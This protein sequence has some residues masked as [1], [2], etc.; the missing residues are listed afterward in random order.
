MEDLEKY[1]PGL[2]QTFYNWFTASSNRSRVEP[3]LTNLQFYKVARGDRVLEIVGGD[4]QDAKFMAKTIKDSHGD[5]QDLVR[6]KVDSNEINYNQTSTSKYSN[7]FVRSRDATS[8]FNIPAE[9]NALPAAEKPARYGQW[10]YL[11]ADCKLIQ[12]P[13]N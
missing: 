1:R 3:T 4:Y 10:F 6:G 12:L 13:G 2:A 9:S 11:D 7:S 8:R 5:W